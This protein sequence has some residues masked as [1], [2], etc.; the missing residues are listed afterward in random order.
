MDLFQAQRER[1]TVRE[2]NR[3]KF[4]VK[5]KEC[6]DFERFRTRLEGIREE[7]REQPLKSNAGR[8]PFDVLVMF[9]LTIL[10]SLYNVSDELLE[11]EALDRS[12]WKDF[13]DITDIRDV[14]DVSTIY[15]FQQM[16]IKSGQY[17]EL[18]KLFD[19]ILCKKGFSAK[20]GQIVDATLVPVPKQRISKSEREVLDKGELPSNW[21]PSK[22]A[23][24]DTEARWFKHPTK[25]STFGYK[26][27]TTVDTEHGLIRSCLVTP[28]NVH[29]GTMLENLLID[30]CEYVFAD[31]G[32]CS[33]KNEEIIE[34]H[35]LTS[36]IHDKA[37]RCHPLTEDQKEFNQLKSIL[38]SRVEHVYGIMH[39]V[40]RTVEIRCIG[41]IRATFQITFRNL[42]YNMHRFV[43]LSGRKEKANS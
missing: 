13:L 26:N 3:G 30:E 36:L 8:R 25:G 14:P 16:L 24:K 7:A 43:W 9:K 18:N 12:S 40:L 4:L 21:T 19:E 2:H 41:K 34:S 5:L 17:G 20:G 11:Y 29:D 33:A 10:K 1:E 31:K 32:F 27:F 37:S 22:T 23:Q 42:A 15:A 35:G 39:Q 28:A 38:R 6:V